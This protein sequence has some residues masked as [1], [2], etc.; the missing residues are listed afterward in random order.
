MPKVV[1][2]RVLVSVSKMRNLKVN[3]DFTIDVDSDHNAVPGSHP[4]H[5]CAAMAVADSCRQTLVWHGVVR[6]TRL[7]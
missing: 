4:P 7:R 1:K 6:I 5:D 2:P 3:G